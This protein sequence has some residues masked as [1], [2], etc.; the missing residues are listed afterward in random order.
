MDPLVLRG[1]EARVLR[2]GVELVLAA[3]E[4]GEADDKQ[5]AALRD[6][7]RAWLEAA[8]QGEP[9]PVLFVPFEGREAPGS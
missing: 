9:R 4:R 5:V 3:R 2:D 8:E 7:V 1:V 6:A